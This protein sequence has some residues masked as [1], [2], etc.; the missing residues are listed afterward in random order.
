MSDSTPK[1]RRRI[2]GQPGN[3]N[4]LKHAL[5]SRLFTEPVKEAFLKWDTKDFTGEMLVLRA[6]MDR[7]ATLLLTG[8]VTPMEAAAMLNALSRASN[9]FSSTVNRHALLNTDDDPIYVAWEDVIAEQDFFSDGEP[10][11]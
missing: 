1:P 5:Y 11:Q 4:A 6:G 8:E 9:S 3:R 10:P 2:G 7:V